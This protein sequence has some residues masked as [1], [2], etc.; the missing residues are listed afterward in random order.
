M[1]KDRVNLLPIEQHDR[2]AR[3]LAPAIEQLV[4]S[5]K[6]E[7]PFD[8]VFTVTLTDQNGRTWKTSVVAGNLAPRTSTDF[9]ELTFKDKLEKVHTRSELSTMLE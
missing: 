8:M 5:G 7:P 1:I 6:Y 9:S 4:E 2:L 3:V